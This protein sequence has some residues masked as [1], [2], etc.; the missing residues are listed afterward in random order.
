MKKLYILTL[1]FLPIVTF[2]QDFVYSVGQTAEMELE[3][4]IYTG[5]DIFFKTADDS[6]VTFEWLLIE[7]TLPDGW[8]F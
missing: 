8:D 2:A 5:A 7:N 6:G 3:A 1:I 4:E